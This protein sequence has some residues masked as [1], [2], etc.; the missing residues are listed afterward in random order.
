M[1]L[2]VNMKC[3]KLDRTISSP[4]ASR[5]PMVSIQI[6]T[7]NEKAWLKLK[8]V[9]ATASTGLISG[10]R[11]YWTTGWYVKYT[12][13]WLLL[14]LLWSIIH[15]SHLLDHKQYS[16]IWPMTHLIYV[17]P[18]ETLHL[19]VFYCFSRIRYALNIYTLLLSFREMLAIFS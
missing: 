14:R 15:D 7:L 8:V 12:W 1:I 13:I 3:F 18:S 5:K 6:K 10:N 19:Q 11:S 17:S 9:P 4:F 2:I 16:H